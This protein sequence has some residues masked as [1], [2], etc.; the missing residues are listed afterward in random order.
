MIVKYKN[1][2]VLQV[3]LIPLHFEKES[4]KIVDVGGISDHEHRCSETFAN[5]AEQCHTFES[6]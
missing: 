4:L 6:F 3:V 2:L 5:S 1:R